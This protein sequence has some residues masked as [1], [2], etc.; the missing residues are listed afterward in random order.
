M[1]GDIFEEN[2]FL[3]RRIAKVN[4]ESRTH[5]TLQIFHLGLMAWTKATSDQITIFEQ[6]TTAQFLGC[7]DRDQ[8]MME[9]L[10]GFG[11]ITVTGENDQRG[12]RDCRRKTKL[13]DGRTVE[14]I[15]D[16]HQR[17]KQDLK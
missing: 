14:Q 2:L 8:T 1:T 16:V 6:S 15:E 13:L 9:V 3:S 17:I 7:F 10:Q 4:E 12:E 11:E 5:V